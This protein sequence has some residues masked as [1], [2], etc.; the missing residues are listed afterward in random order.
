M[1]AV[2]LSWVDVEGFTLGT[3][4][5][6]LFD[7]G[8]VVEEGR[9]DSDETVGV[10]DE[11]G[12]A[13]VEDEAEVEA[14]A[15]FFSRVTCCT[16]ADLGTCGR[17]AKR[18][19]QK[20][21]GKQERGAWVGFEK[22]GQEESADYGECIFAEC[23]NVLGY[24]NG[25]HT[26]AA[27]SNRQTETQPWRAAGWSHVC[28]CVHVCVCLGV[29]PFSFESVCCSIHRAECARMGTAASHGATEFLISCL[30]R[31]CATADRLQGGLDRRRIAGGE[32]EDAE[33]GGRIVGS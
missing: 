31:V 28:M 5:S 29:T 23:T 10:A 26:V 6:G 4:G 13:E 14:V 24:R 19:E 18:D 20:R 17:M 3:V 25:A 11:G 1:S 12:L 32:N 33:V 2:V 21:A 22:G 15:V 8:S 7:V 9:V 27:T 16:P 30:P